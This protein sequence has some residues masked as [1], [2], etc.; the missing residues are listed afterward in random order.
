MAKPCDMF[1]FDH[2]ARHHSQ[3]IHGSSDAV[4]RISRKSYGRELMTLRGPYVL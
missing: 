1:D 2:Q 4:N 3:K